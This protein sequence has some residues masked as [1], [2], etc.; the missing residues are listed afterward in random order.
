MA[1]SGLK[2]GW[3]LDQ[4]FGV[5]IGLQLITHLSP[6]LV[7][8]EDGKVLYLVRWRRETLGQRLG[9]AL[10]RH[11]SNHTG[12]GFGDLGRATYQ[13]DFH[14]CCLPFLMFEQCISVFQRLR[15]D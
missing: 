12:F 3:P 1:F 13:F 4:Q 7:A 8:D 6:V 14:G 10:A 11:H 5:G 15:P 2:T 9:C